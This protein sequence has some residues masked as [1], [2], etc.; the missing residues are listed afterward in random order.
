VGGVDCG[1]DRYVP[2]LGSVEGGDGRIF[3]SYKVKQSTNRHSS[4]QYRDRKE[5]CNTTITR[6]KLGLLKLLRKFY[7]W[8]M[9]FD[10]ERERK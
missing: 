3:S 9:S 4:L 6:A 5:T 2:G 8:R 10:W 1:N 7:Y